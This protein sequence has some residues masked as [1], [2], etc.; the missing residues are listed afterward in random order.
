[1]NL[2]VNTVNV[3]ISTLLV[4]TK[5][6]DIRAIFFALTKTLQKNK[7]LDLEILLKIYVVHLLFFLQYNTQIYP[8]LQ[9]RFIR[10]CAYHYKDWL[11]CEEKN[12]YTERHINAFVIFK[13]LFLWLYKEVLQK[14]KEERSVSFLSLSLTFVKE[15]HLSLILVQIIASKP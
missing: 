12:N 1:M 11:G 5:Y 15:R 14:I 10:Q 9:S 13:T 4:F 6:D 7:I 3:K 2:M 8:S